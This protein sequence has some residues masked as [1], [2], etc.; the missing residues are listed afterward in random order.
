MQRRESLGRRRITLL[1][2]LMLIAIFLLPHSLR[3]TTCIVGKKFKT[4][5]VCGVVK[6][7]GGAVIPD[8]TVE[9]QKPGV[10]QAL[11]VHTDTGR[12][13]HFS[14]VA[15]GEYVLRVKFSGFWDAAQPFVVE[16]ATKTEKNCTRPIRVV[17]KPAG[18]CSY[19][20]NAWKRK[21]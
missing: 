17:M 16:R 20:E 10:P 18:Q 7:F 21:D 15:D 2:F 14:T 3:A 8:A 6:D 19:V 13:F 9:L 12:G 11:Q 5:Q 1:E 4:R